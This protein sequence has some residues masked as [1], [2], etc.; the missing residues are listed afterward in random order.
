MIYTAIH[1]QI[2]VVPL[3]EDLL[4]IYDISSALHNLIEYCISYFS[5]LYDKISNK[6]NIRIIKLIWAQGSM[7]RDGFSASL[8]V[9]AAKLQATDP[10]VSAMRK[11]RDEC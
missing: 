2:H 3:L 4:R 1:P 9:M 5:L 8:Q 10:I 11:Q 7:N 6:S